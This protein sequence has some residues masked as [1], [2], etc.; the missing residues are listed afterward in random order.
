MSSSLMSAAVAALLLALAQPSAAATLEL[1]LR[2]VRPTGEVCVELRVA[3]QRVVRRH[4]VPARGVVL[5]LRLEALPA[6]RYAVVVDQV[7]DEA[8]LFGRAPVSWWRSRQGA[9][10]VALVDGVR[11]PLPIYLRSGR[12]AAITLRTGA[13]TPP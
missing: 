3:P 9:A 11:T 4:C 6:G 13:G 12:A 5:P 1:Q 2:N 10:T 8:G 7:G